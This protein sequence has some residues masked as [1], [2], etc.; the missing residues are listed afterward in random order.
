MSAVFVCGSGRGVA[1]ALS[2]EP[3]CVPPRPPLAALCDAEPQD[4]RTGRELRRQLVRS[5]VRL[6]LGDGSAVAREE[7]QSRADPRRL[8][9][10]ASGRAA[11]LGRCEQGGERP[12]QPEAL[13]DGFEM[14]DP[15]ANVDQHGERVRHPGGQSSRVPAHLPQ[16]VAEL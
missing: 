2:A 8:Q 3:D 13:R 4:V 10:P 16:H 7:L 1:S 15:V 5:G 9:E 14:R 6:C 12:I 11:V